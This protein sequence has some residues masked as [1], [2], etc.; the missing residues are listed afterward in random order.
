MPQMLIKNCVFGWEVDPTV[1]NPNNITNVLGNIHP[2][3]G[4][5]VALWMSFDPAP[6]WFY[7]ENVLPSYLFTNKLI[8]QA[9]INF[10]E[11]DKAT[12]KAQW[13]ADCKPLLDGDNDATL[14]VSS[15]LLENLKVKVYP[16][17]VIDEM[18]IEI[19]NNLNTNLKVK[20][21]DISGKQ[22]MVKDFGNT[23]MPVLQL[24]SLSKGLYFINIEANSFVSTI[25]I[26]K[27]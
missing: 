14:S 20:V 11:N 26:I 24:Q 12:F 25:R 7:D 10:A 1:N 13:I 17:P 16:N 19:G 23:N 5:N 2:D 6:S 9:A 27:E 18:Q 8:G 3:S 22:L 4:N 21:Y 15:S